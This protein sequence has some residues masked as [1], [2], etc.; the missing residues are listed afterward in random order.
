MLARATAGLPPRQ[1]RSQGARLLVLLVSIPSLLGHS[2]GSVPADAERSAVSDRSQLVWESQDFGSWAHREAGSRIQLCANSTYRT[3]PEDVFLGGVHKHKVPIS[4]Q[5]SFV[6]NHT[7]VDFV[8]RRIVRTGLIVGSPMK[9]EDVSFR[10]FCPVASC[11]W[12]P[13]PSCQSTS[14]LLSGRASPRKLWWTRYQR[15]S[16]RR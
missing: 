14:Q 5:I 9:A 6:Q 12:T 3:S 4:I 15:T 10:F 16:H 2:R 8:A 11:V 7:R 1:K 13:G